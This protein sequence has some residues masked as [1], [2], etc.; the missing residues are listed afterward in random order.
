MPRLPSYTRGA[1][2]VLNPPI[3]FSLLSSV[4]GLSKCKVASLNP[5]WVPAHLGEPAVH[6]SELQVQKVLAGEAA[7][8]AAD[9][10]G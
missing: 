10:V 8:K 6:H 3:T 1:I 7:A 2:P 9:M 4:C 5:M